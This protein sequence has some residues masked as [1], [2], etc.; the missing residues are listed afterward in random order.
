MRD[1]ALGWLITSAVVI[2][3]ALAASIS[4]SMPASEA[5]AAANSA[6]CGVNRPEDM[7]MKGCML[8]AITL[9]LPI[10]TLPAGSSP[11]AWTRRPIRRHCTIVHIVAALIAAGYTASE[12]K[13]LIQELDYKKFKDASPLDKIPV[14][15]PL[16]SLTLEKG[17][18]EGKFFENWIRELLRQKNVETFNDLVLQ[19]YRGVWPFTAL[20]STVPLVQ[21]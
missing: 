16:T 15:G 10:S 3:R 4:P 20:L 13:E 1:K 17:I 6:E 18:Y 14:L 2:A 9:T 12:L 5:A 8:G 21:W 11:I 7:A 19:D